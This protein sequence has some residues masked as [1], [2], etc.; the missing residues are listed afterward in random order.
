MQQGM[1]QKN[2]PSRLESIENGYSSIGK[3]PWI[4]M[5]VLYMNVN[6]LHPNNG[7]HISFKICYAVSK[8]HKTNNNILMLNLRGLIRVVQIT[9]KNRPIN[10]T[11]SKNVGFIYLFNYL[12]ISFKYWTK[13]A[14]MEC[15]RHYSIEHWKIHPAITLWWEFTSGLFCP[16]SHKAPMLALRPSLSRL[17]LA[18]PRAARRGYA[19]A[20]SVTREFPVQV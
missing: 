11:L 1:V 19:P 5:S 3:L 4:N 12:N 17:F 6:C 14:C 18:R 16:F 7:N 20:H 9:P 10:E 15:T 2:M 13:I 8:I